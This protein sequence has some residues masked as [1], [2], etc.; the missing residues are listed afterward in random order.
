M[1]VP[2][3]TL[4][5]LKNLLS[6]WNRHLFKATNASKTS[7]CQ[8]FQNPPLSI[9]WAW[10]T[11]VLLTIALIIAVGPRVAWAQ[12]DQP[13]LDELLEITPPVDPAAPDPHPEDRSVSELDPEVSRALSDSDPGD[14]FDQAV[15]QMGEAADRL[16]QHHDVGLNTQRLQQEVIEKLDQAIALARQQQSK[17]GA[18]GSSGSSGQPQQQQGGSAGNAAQ[19]QAGGSRAIAGQGVSPGSGGGAPIDGR[20]AADQ[21]S[22]SMQSNRTEWGN[23][24]ARLRA[25]LQQGINERFSSIYREMTGEYYRRL[26]EEGN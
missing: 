12:S 8:V 16:D 3:N 17:G 23:L 4:G 22:G 9:G 7:Q 15:R 1:K 18:S 14:V 25:E 24:P 11:G 6:D 19:G 26:A 13:T 2:V 5:V 10:G 20:D 21:A